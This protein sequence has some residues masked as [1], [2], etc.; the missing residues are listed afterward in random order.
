MV[1]QRLSDQ[2][3]ILKC[4]GRLSNANAFNHVIDIGR[5]ANAG[6]AS[7][8]NNDSELDIDLECSYQWYK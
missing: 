2:Q 7:F 6:E 3:S 4:S 1:T 8:P 5:K